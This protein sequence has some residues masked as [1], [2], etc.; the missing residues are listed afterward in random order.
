MHLGDPTAPI[1]ESAM[2]ILRPIGLAIAALFIGVNAAWLLLIPVEMLGGPPARAWAQPAM[3][4][5][6]AITFVLLLRRSRRKRMQ[7]AQRVAEGVAPPSRTGSIM[8]AGVL[9]LIFGGAALWIALASDAKDPRDVE[10]GLFM[11][12][13]GVTTIAAV[14]R[15]RRQRRGAG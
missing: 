2:R 11:L 7:V 3:Y 13:A 9:A 5:L 14:V 8:V 6:S 4:G 15:R 10:V 12:L 1:P